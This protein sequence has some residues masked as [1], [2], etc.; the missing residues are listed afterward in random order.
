[1][2]AS[3]A[4]SKSSVAHKKK[5]KKKK[6]TSTAAP[7]KRWAKPLTY[8]DAKRLHTQKKRKALFAT[9]GL[10][11]SSTARPKAAR[12]SQ[13]QKNKKKADAT[14]TP[15]LI[16]K[17]QK[18]EVY[19]LQLEGGYVYVGKMSKVTTLHTN[20]QRLFYIGVCHDSEAIDM[21]KLYIS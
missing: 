14:K 15:K 9:V 16:P 19:V 5:K 2:P 21:P 11:G 6:G 12:A 4:S 8:K 20:T 7:K 17:K 18:S 13:A 1:M 3:S 10:K